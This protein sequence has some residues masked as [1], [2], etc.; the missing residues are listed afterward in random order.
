MKILIEVTNLIKK[1]GKHIA[2][3]DIS[4]TVNK[5]EILGFLGPNGAGK[6]TTMN[7]LTGY[8]S[9][10]SGSIKISGVDILEN[11]IEAKKHIGYLPEIPPLYLDMT[12]VDYLIFVA[13]LKKVSKSEL[14]A[15]IAEILERTELTHVQKRLI[16]NLSKGYKQRVGLASAL[17]GSPDVLILDEPTVGLDPKQIIEMR[18]LIKDL[19]QKHTIILSSHI[20]PEISAIC[21]S[22]MIINKGNM[23][24]LDTPENLKHLFSN[25]LLT[26]IRVQQADDAF[27]NALKA[28]KGVQEVTLVDS[29]EENMIDISISSDKA[30]D[31][32]EELF[33]ACVAQ[34][35]P[36]FML[37]SREISLEDIFLKVTEQF[38]DKPAES[39]EGDSDLASVNTTKEGVL[40]E[41]DI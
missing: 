12:V 11:P 38:E 36:L 3:N 22:I 20:L 30:Y 34:N 1:Y 39:S 33:S 17:M 24:A 26:T 41:N 37:K 5:G 23:V 40:D 7:M 18:N 28:I 4:F 2:V 21:D 32:R 13:K 14:K 29:E 10:T 16:K 15:H 9:S 31:I 8:L 6:S 27:I 25:N 19:S 35:H